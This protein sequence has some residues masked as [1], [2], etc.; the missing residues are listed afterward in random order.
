MKVAIYFSL[1]II[2]L[3][4]LN[5]INQIINFPASKFI[6]Q[7]ILTIS[8]N[9]ASMI[10]S[11]DKESVIYWRVYKLTDPTPP[12]KEFT[13]TQNMSNIIAYGGG[14]TDQTRTHYTNFI[15]NLQPQTSYKLT[16]IAT[17]KIGKFPSK[18]IEI[19]F[20]TK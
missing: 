14:I 18:V 5:L 3:F 7:K 1:L 19:S 11:T 13:N 4:F 17:P 6:E 2:M 12:A 8:T 10:F 20:D 16:A 9:S 15:S